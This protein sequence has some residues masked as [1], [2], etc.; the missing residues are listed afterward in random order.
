[1]PNISLSSKGLNKLKNNFYENNFKF[2]I[3]DKEEYSI[4]LILVDFFSPF[5]FK[6][7]Q[8]DPTLLL[9]K[10]EIKNYQIDH[11][12]K[13]VELIYGEEI[14]FKEEEKDF[15]IE[16]SNSLGNKEIIQKFI[17]QIPQKITK[18]NVINIILEKDKYDI[19][20]KKEILYL[21]KNFDHFPEDQLKNLKI[22]HLID[23]ISNKKTQI[24]NQKKLFRFVSHLIKE[25][26]SDYLQLLYY[27]KIENLDLKK[28][29]QFIGIIEKNDLV[30]TFWEIL[31]KFFLNNN[32]LI[33]N[34]ENILFNGNYFNGI[35][36]YLKNKNKSSNI[37][38]SGIINITSSTLSGG[39][40][41]YILDDNSN[42]FMSSPN[43][44]DYLIFD[45]KEKKLN[46][47]GYSIRSYSG[48]YANYYNL[49]YWKV[50][51]SDDLS[52]WYDLD[53][54]SNDSSLNNK[55]S[56]NYFS[57]TN[58]NNNFYRYIKI[59]ITNTNWNGN[60]YMML[61]YL[62]LFGELKF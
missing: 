9:I 50:S 15:L 61:E 36:N 6:I 45:L 24:E 56:Q 21:A 40:Q 57:C 39:S 1:M 11:F 13:I 27:I 49:R 53:N 51:G 41:S 3:N 48:G 54:R 37:H 59:Q 26:G 10:I 33:E 58:P 44:N 17:D 55:S 14:E 31:K 35:F 52:N 32:K 23:L 18:D 60:W 8:S 4:P 7:H 19:S 46:L 47:K 43:G 22:D 16:L 34:K 12:K 28:I 38:N 5:L 2:I 62:D 25:K 42:Y 29:K 30:L 20:Y